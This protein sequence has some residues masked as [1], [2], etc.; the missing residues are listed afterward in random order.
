ML[1]SLADPIYQETNVRPQTREPFLIIGKHL[2]GLE[3]GLVAEG[4]WVSEGGDPQI[5]GA[6]VPV[7][8]LRSLDHQCIVLDGKW[9]TQIS[10]L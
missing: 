8:R 6:K 3:N 10:I 4:R 5:A 1:P 9:S 2:H 7:P